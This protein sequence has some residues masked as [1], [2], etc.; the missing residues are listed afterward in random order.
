MMKSAIILAA[1]A[2]TATAADLTSGETIKTRVMPEWRVLADSRDD[3][4]RM[5]YVYQVGNERVILDSKPTTLARAGEVQV[6]QYQEPLFDTLGNGIC[7]D[8]INLF[9]Q[10]FPDDGINPPTYEAWEGTANVPAN[11]VIDTISFA[12]S[13]LDEPAATA[14]DGV[15]DGVPFND[16][17]IIIEENE[18]AIA[19][20]NP[21]TPTLNRFGVALLDLAGSDEAPPAGSVDVF[22]YT[23][24]LTDDMGGDGI[25]FELG[26][27]DATGAEA[28]IDEADEKND[29]SFLDL[30][31][32]LLDNPD[33]TDSLHDASFTMFFL[34]P[35]AD[36]SGQINPQDPFDRLDIIPQGFLLGF[37]EAWSIADP[38]DYANT[39]PSTLAQPAGTGRASKNLVR[40]WDLTIEPFL[41]GPDFTADPFVGEWLDENGAANLG[42]GFRTTGAAQN[43]VFVNNPFIEAEIG[44]NQFDVNCNEF[45]Y[46]SAD[47]TQSVTIP[48]N[49]GSEPYIG[50]LGPTPGTCGDSGPMGCSPAD[51]AAPFG[52]IDL[53]DVDAFIAA[54][55]SGDPAADL[56]APFGVI[57]LTDVDTFIPLFLAGCP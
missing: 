50:L 29:N 20:D 10:L 31:V 14:G 18:D 15:T 11:S 7:P 12:A 55:L 43:T 53:S 45:V 22:L 26:D 47:G 38:T 3:I 34:Q 42:G 44:L 37:S 21:A 33:T 40:F 51:L 27:D 13:A 49:G 25:E 6:Y 17:V 4:N 16:A 41:L 2:G 35:L 46:T 5:G 36:G 9:G 8:A 24:D 30:G 19:D 1:L 39:F 56:A 52:I 48:A 28:C 54:F 32:T 57:D 23:V